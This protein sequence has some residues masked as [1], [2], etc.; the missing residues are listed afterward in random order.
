MSIIKYKFAYNS[1]KEIIDVQNLSKEDKS[2][3]HKFECLSCGHEMIAV[4]GEKR[5]KHFRHKVI[6]EINCS[7]ETYLHKLAKIKFHETYQNCLKNNKPFNIKIFMNRECNFYEN[8]FTLTCELE[9]QKMTFDLTKHFKKISVESREQSFIPDILLETENQEKM[10]FE[11]AVTHEST[12]EKINSG[13]RIIEFTILSETDIEIIESCLLEESEAIRFFNFK[14]NL[15]K[16]WCQ[17]KC[18]N[19][20]MPY[21]KESVLYCAFVVDKNGKSRFVNE[22]L[23]KIKQLQQ[24]SLYFEYI[25]R[26]EEIDLSSLYKE[27]VVKTYKN[28]IRVKNCFLCRY[29][30]VNYSYEKEGS[31]FC[32]FLKNTGSSNMAADCQYFLPDSKVFIKYENYA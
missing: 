14:N 15:I 29:H 16:G 11:V 6:T 10:F 12:P 21:V 23:D 26:S 24:N 4:I 32:K 22:E 9:P 31:I 7:P 25:S 17:G 13:Y 18:R 2:S 19:G 8:D 30:G 1:Q 3:K 20:I 5:I 27:K 28:G